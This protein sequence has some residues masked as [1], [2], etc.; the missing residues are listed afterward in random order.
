M[1]TN[2]LADRP[3][4]SN[5]KG[6]PPRARAKA[7]TARRID[8]IDAQAIREGWAIKTLNDLS[9]RTPRPPRR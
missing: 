4:P 6:L 5:G 7:T 9:V 1:T 2:G 8:D 3:R